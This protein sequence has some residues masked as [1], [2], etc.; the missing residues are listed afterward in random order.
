M[1]VNHC[2]YM[3]MCVDVDRKQTVPVERSL[4]SMLVCNILSRDSS[5]VKT[6]LCLPLSIPICVS[7][8]SDNRSR[9]RP[10]CI[11]TYVGQHHSL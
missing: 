9:L 6:A 4:N 7:W 2:K 10:T 8:E 1:C 5:E 3:W 11:R